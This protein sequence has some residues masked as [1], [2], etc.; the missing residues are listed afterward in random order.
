MAF[1]C[2]E[3]KFF[4]TKN[5]PSTEHIS[6]G[7]Y[8]PQTIHRKMKKSFAP[9][10]SSVEKKTKTKMN[11]IPLNHSKNIYLFNYEKNK[12]SVGKNLKKKNN[13]KKI[14]II[15]YPEN[16]KDL[17]DNL[18]IRNL[19]KMKITRNDKGI[20]PKIIIDSY[21]NTKISNNNNKEKFITES[22]TNYT[23]N[24]GNNKNILNKTTSENWYSRI[25]TKY[26]NELLLEFDR[27][28][29]L[30][31][32]AFIS[33]I[34]GKERSY[35]YSIEDNGDMTPKENPDNLQIFSG[36][37]RD[38]V[39]PGNY[40][41]NIKWNKTLSL[42]SKSKTKRFS[43]KERKEENL[44]DFEKNMAEKDKH[45]KTFSSDFY[46]NP[47]K[48]KLNNKLNINT[49]NIGYTKESLLKPNGDYITKNFDRPG[50]TDNFFINK[51]NVLYPGPG[52][53]YEDDKWSCMKILR[54][55]GKT[56]KNFNFGSDVE[57]FENINDE[58]S[59]N[60]L[61]DPKEL[62]KKKLKEMK[63]KTPLPTTYF[64]DDLKKIFYL[65]N[66]FRSTQKEF[67]FK[68]IF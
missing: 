48:F 5:L 55:P 62:Y 15:K 32:R 68:H 53:Y 12:F 29:N 64:K 66:K 27:D 9:F 35:G 37:G 58:E 23:N 61:E 43:P 30:N 34:P 36:L 17:K 10:G 7:F 44:K 63:L 22:Y 16:E 60:K 38:T 24:F 65:K 19:N 14:R 45:S 1:L 54:I 42:W 18:I 33:S 6:P 49:F 3:E 39:G 47:K 41:I 4:W 50:R 67:K 59:E 57:R 28:K 20:Y 40:D 51:L 11:E 46:L 26:N 8:I 13:K 31:K 21:T 56:R 2:N 52:Y 25:R